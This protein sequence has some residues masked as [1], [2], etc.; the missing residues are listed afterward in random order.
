MINESYCLAIPFSICLWAHPYVPSWTEFSVNFQW[1]IYSAFIHFP[2]DDGVAGNCGWRWDWFSSK[3]AIK[4]LHSSLT[5]PPSLPHLPPTTLHT[6]VMSSPSSTGPIVVPFSCTPNRSRIIGRSGRTANWIWEQERTSGIS[7]KILNN[8]MISSVFLMA[9][10]CCC[11]HPG[12]SKKA[13]EESRAK[14]NQLRK[15]RI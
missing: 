14:E 1:L 8:T 15:Y 11:R 13:R 10:L 9:F 3:T 2:S 5:P 12:P 7:E 6:S 4:V